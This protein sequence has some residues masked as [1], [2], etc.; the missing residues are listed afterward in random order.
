MLNYFT[1]NLPTSARIIYG[2]IIVG[3]PKTNTHR[4]MNTDSMVV[5]FDSH[6]QTPHIKASLSVILIACIV[7]V[8]V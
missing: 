1:W 3:P 2:I 7:F 4:H 8:L 5:T 6:A